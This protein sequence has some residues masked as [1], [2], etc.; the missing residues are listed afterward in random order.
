MSEQDKISKEDRKRLKLESEFWGKINHL[1]ELNL[2]LEKIQ[3]K[4]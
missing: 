4:K 3:K 2:P 1:R